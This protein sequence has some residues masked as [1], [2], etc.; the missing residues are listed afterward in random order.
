MQRPVFEHFENNYSRLRAGWLSC[1]RARHWAAGIG[2]TWLER[3]VVGEITQACC[4]IC[5]VRCIGGGRIRKT[6]KECTVYGYSIGFGR[7]DHSIAAQAIQ[8]AFPELQVDWNDEG[9][10]PNMHYSIFIRHVQRKNPGCSVIFRMIILVLLF[11][12]QLCSCSIASSGDVIVFCKYCGENITTFDQVITVRSDEAVGRRNESFPRKVCDSL[13]PWKLSF[14]SRVELIWVHLFC[15]KSLLIR[16]RFLSKYWQS[17][18]QMFSLL[19]LEFHQIPS[20]LDMT[21]Q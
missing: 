3:Y 20:S 15:C 21:G 7:P 9:Y 13:I 18:K 8:E 6:A 5:L 16:K 19:G 4:K 11:L 2:S 17:E 1:R 12:L 14:D 10:W